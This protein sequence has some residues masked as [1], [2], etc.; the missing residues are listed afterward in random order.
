MDCAPALPRPAARPS[1][2]RNLRAQD[3]WLQ[4]DRIYPLACTST[5][6]AAQEGIIIQGTLPSASA[7]SPPALLARAPRTLD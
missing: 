7:L 6:E 3:A 1:F 4:D 2:H 5:V